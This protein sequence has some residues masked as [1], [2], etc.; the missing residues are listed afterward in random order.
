MARN[1]KMDFLDWLKNRDAETGI[2]PNVPLDLQEEGGTYTGEAEKIHPKGWMPQSVEDSYDMYSLEE[3]QGVPGMN[4]YKSHKPYTDYMNSFKEHKKPAV[5]PSVPKKPEK[6]QDPVL[7][8]DGNMTPL[9]ALT[10]GKEI[11]PGA[12]PEQNKTFL[13][14]FL[15]DKQILSGEPPAG[16]AQSGLPQ[17]EAAKLKA[18]AARKA[19]LLPDGIGKLS[20]SNS[21]SKTS[22]DPELK[23]WLMKKFAMDM[24]QGNTMGQESAKTRLLSNLGAAFNTFG[25]GLAGGLKPDQA[26]YDG[27]NKQAGTREQEMADKRKQTSQDLQAAAKLA[28]EREMHKESISVAREGLKR[29]AEDRSAERLSVRLEKSGLSELDSV[30]ENLNYLLKK[31]EGKDLPGYGMTRLLPDVAISDGGKLRQGVRQLENILLKAR[32]GA[33]VTP[34]EYDRFMGEISSSATKSDDQL[35]NGIKIVLNGLD[36][37][38]QGILSGY[39]HE[40]KQRLV[41]QGGNI[42][43]MKLDD[44]VKMT[45]GS[46]TRMVPRK[47]I[48]AA[49]SEGYREVK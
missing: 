40:T 26:F 44:T 23:E 3:R 34:Q 36:A 33:A 37:K 27:L 11:V 42:N 20:L 16:V 35:R 31:H 30:S 43:S 4:D 2:N 45:N 8:T 25:S 17:D 9:A 39:T 13:N 46:E 38:K 28:Q 10:A 29:G 22:N 5:P 14:K 24:E 48:K 47:H 18:F 6:R 19:G 7:E 49:Q 41:E 1:S 21:S 15:E 12:V 32:S